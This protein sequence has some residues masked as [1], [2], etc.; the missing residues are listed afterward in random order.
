ML[1]FFFMLHFFYDRESEKKKGLN[2][3]ELWVC[4]Y[5]TVTK[6]CF[7]SQAKIDMCGDQK[8]PYACCCCFLLSLRNSRRDSGTAGWF[9]LV[10][11]DDEGGCDGW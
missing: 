6:K 3:V 5:L 11:H 9:N 8:F 2:S 1:H 10:V 7:W 4:V